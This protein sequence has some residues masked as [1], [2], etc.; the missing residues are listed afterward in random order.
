M[1]G[2]GVGN[3]WTKVVNDWGL[4]EFGVRKA[5][6]ELALLPVVEEL[7][8]EQVFD[9]IGHSVGR[10]IYS[11]VSENVINYVRQHLPARSGPGSFVLEAVL[12][13]CQPET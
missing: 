7:G 2:V 4:G 13:D 10:V 11:R 6:S 1:S 12:D 8:H 5:G 3:N 9:L